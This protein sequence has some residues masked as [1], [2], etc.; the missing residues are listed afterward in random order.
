[1]LSIPPWMWACA[2]A[3]FIGSFLGVVVARHDALGSV[4]T[5]RS[6]CGSCGATLDARDLVPIV[7]WLASRGHCRHCGLA[8]GWFYPVIEIGALLVAV[9]SSLVFSGA[10]LWISC[11][12]GWALLALAAADFKYLLLPDFLTLPL[13]VAGLLVTW[14]LDPA[15]LA[16]HAIGAAAGFVAVVALRFVYERL[17]GR[18]GMG[19]GDAKLLAAA[20]A[21]TSWE[22]LPSILVL[23]A[24]SALIFALLRGARAGQL[25][26]V[27]RVPFGPF[28]A[29]GFWIVWLY[30]P[31]VAS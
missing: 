29:G 23:A 2:L 7:S 8:V 18:E 26:L 31:L 15:A 13:V 17:R 11:G 19:L 14:A 6:A 16:A 9:W 5:G 22:G 1:L 10:A 24:V 20:G 28:L 25:S 4:V 27:D 3:P 21:W 12:L 30:G